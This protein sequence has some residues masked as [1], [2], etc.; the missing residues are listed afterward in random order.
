MANTCYGPTVKRFCEMILIVA[1]TSFAMAQGM[2][3]GGQADL[4]ACQWQELPDECGKHKQFYSFVMIACV[5]PLLL[6]PDFKKLSAFSSFFIFCCIT[7]LV[8]IVAFEIMTVQ[9]RL[10]GV[11]LQLTY[12]DEK[13]AVVKASPSRIDKAF[14]FEYFNVAFFPLFLGEVM[15]IFEGNV[16]LLN[17]YSQ[18]NQPRSMFRQTAITHLVVGVLCIAIG[19]LSYL[20]Y[21]DLTQDIV[22]Y[23]L[24]QGS[25][26]ATLVAILYMFNIAGSITMTIQPI[27]GL[28]EKGQA[29]KA[30]MD[31]PQAAGEHSSPNLQ[32]AFVSKSDAGADDDEIEGEVDL[33]QRPSLGD[34]SSMKS[35]EDLRLPE[36]EP[37]SACE[38]LTFYVRRLAIPFGIIGLSTLFPNVNMIL[39]LLA[40]DVCGVCLIVLPILFYRSA[41][42]QR[43]SKKSRSL[44]IALGYLI[45]LL[46]IPI[47][48]TGIY[49]NMRQLLFGG[50][51]LEPV[52]VETLQAVA[53]GDSLAM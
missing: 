32:E 38:N 40:G 48:M 16:G 46:T 2:Y 30:K 19:C 7:S 5:S 47:G 35:M 34:G 31:L 27:Y 49:L 14:E 12:S 41:Y 10:S 51:H 44:Q 23:N 53:E 3:L 29:R 15:S 52:A 20:A 26:L 45:I 13:G 18:Q 50:Q 22:L 28:F 11:P 33:N 8:C 17:I 25:K 4:L 21:G 24:P 9:Q 42:I 43:P 37:A 6:I 1:N 39:S 36:E